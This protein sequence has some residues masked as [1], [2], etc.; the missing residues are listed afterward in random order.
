[1]GGG[2]STTVSVGDSSPRLESIRFEF[3]EETAGQFG[4]S[5]LNVPPA[6]TDY[7]RNYDTVV[8][9]FEVTP[10][11]PVRDDPG[12]V[13][14][15]L[16]RSRLSAIGADPD[17]LQVERY[18]KSAGTWETLEHELVSSDDSTV[19]IRFETPGFPTGD[20]GTPAYTTFAIT[21]APAGA[22]SSDAGDATTESETATA[23]APVTTTETATAAGTTTAVETTTSTTFPGFGVATVVSALAI[24]LVVA[25][26]RR[27][28]G[29]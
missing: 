12:T 1:M 9:L 7:P 3:G 28:T 20:F 25:T 26:R 18:N 4:V 29:R 15:A 23:T 11:E 5:E 8:S 22:A 24:V 6:D 16:D 10:P 19:T 17:G 14:V 21:T 13:T 2:S 27:R